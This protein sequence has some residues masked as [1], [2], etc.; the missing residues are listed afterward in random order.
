MSES[1]E[2]VEPPP[3]PAR[4]SRRRPRVRLGAIV[5]LAVAAGVIAWVVLE[6]DRTSSSSQ[7]PTSTISA[8][9]PTSTEQGAATVSH[10]GPVGLNV[11]GLKSLAATLDQPVYWAGPKAG[12]RYEFTRTTDGK[13]YVRYL[14]RGVTVG[15]SRANFLIIATYP[16]VNAL[17]SLRA[18]ANGEGASI[19]GGGFALPDAAYPQSTHLAFPGVDYQVEVYDPSPKR[20]RRVGLSGRVQPVQ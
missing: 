17:K 19:P 6:R 3:A 2:H 9:T 5:A 20:S 16:F 14:P 15:D 1:S 13:T 7:A 18:V 4:S 11:S 8:Q 12:Y 10:L